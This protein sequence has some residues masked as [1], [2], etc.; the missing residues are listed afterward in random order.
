NGTDAAGN[1]AVQ[2]TRTVNVI[3]NLKPTITITGANPVN[4]ECGVP[5]AHP[6]ATAFDQCNLN[7]TSSISTDGLPVDV[8]STGTRTIRYNV[9]DTNTNAADE[10]IRTVNVVDT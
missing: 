2:R 10:A 3:D 4:V 6:G 5:Y 1:P 9:S 8:S 7:L